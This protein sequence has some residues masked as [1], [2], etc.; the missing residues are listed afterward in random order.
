MRAYN[1]V[2]VLTHDFDRIQYR[3]RAIDFDQQSFEGNSKVYKPQYL[4][5]NNT[6]VNMSLELLQRGSIEQYENEERSLLAKRAISS[7]YRL[8]NLLKCMQQDQLSTKE[9]IKQLKGELFDL[10]KDVK[11]KKSTNMG[12]ILKSALDFIIRN[13][14]TENPYIIN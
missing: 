9:K 1:Y 6:L 14:K 8:D 4:K 12:D 7:S 5:E 2:V 3:L 11:F 13:Y 10:T